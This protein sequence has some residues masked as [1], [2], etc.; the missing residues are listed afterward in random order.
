MD[1]FP[2]ILSVKTAKQP[3]CKLNDHRFIALVSS[4]THISQRATPFFHTSRR[5][6]P[7]GSIIILIPS[8]SPPICVIWRLCPNPPL[9]LYCRSWGSGVPGFKKERARSLTTEG[10][11]LATAHHNNRNGN[12]T[13]KPT[14][15]EVAASVNG[16][17]DASTLWR[18]V[19]YPTL[20]PHLG[21][22][23]QSGWNINKFFNPQ[24]PFFVHCSVVLKTVALV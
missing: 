2:T 19:Y 11:V 18:Y 9:R 23:Y 1:V 10:K 12:G 6:I 7:I 24:G 16:N 15:W 4:L 17:K 14:E 20:L 8:H 22:L 21:A 13:S 5:R 3:T